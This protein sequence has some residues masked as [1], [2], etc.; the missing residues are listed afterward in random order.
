MSRARRFASSLVPGLLLSAAAL[1]QTAYTVREANV[2]A[3]PERDY[4]VVTRLAA[5]T[6]V[7][8]AGCNEDSS[9]CEVIAGKSMP[10]DGPAKCFGFVQ[11]YDR[12]PKRRL[13][14]VLKSQGMQANQ[15]VTFLTDGGDD[16]RELPLYLNPRPSIC[17]I[18]FMSR[19]A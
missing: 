2:R 10:T 11:T 6:E 1:A 19:C 5:G 15:Q 3:G 16:V 12:K 17:S 14:E 18:G 8:V 7:S 13:F 4:P 9:W